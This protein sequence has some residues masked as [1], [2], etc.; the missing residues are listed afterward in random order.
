MSPEQ[1]NALR[2]LEDAIPTE[3][4]TSRHGEGF[5]GDRYETIRSF[6][7]SSSSRSE[8]VA[9]LREALELALATMEMQEKREAGIFHINQAAALEIWNDAKET[10]RSALKEN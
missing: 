10:A 7:A 2:A 3:L 1:L 6:I 9:R 5:L 4:R 8:E